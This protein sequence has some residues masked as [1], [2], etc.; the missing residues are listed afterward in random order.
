LP[1]CSAVMT[2]SASS[3]P[4]LSISAVQ[5]WGIC[6][7]VCCA[8]LTGIVPSWSGRLDSPMVWS[9]AAFAQS[10]GKIRSY[11]GAVLEIEPLRRRAYRD[12]RRIM[13]GNLPNDVCRQGQLPGNVQSICTGF[14]D[15]SANIIRKNNLSI[16]EFN[17][18]TQR[19]QSDSSLM[20]LIQQEL[21]RQQQR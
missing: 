16:G 4:I 15:E 14:F 13:N 10:A 2:H 7:F 6:L 3:R 18:L 21:I 9:S 11:A 17:D 20:N 8:W 19:S 12:V 5:G 1:E